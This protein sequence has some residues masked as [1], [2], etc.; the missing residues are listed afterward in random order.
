MIGGVYCTGQTRRAARL[1]SVMC[2]ITL[3]ATTGGTTTLVFRREK[4][5]V[6]MCSRAGH[7]E[8]ENILLD[9]FRPSPWITTPH[10]PLQKQTATGESLKY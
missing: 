7:E 10:C 8:K 6:F 4:R 2:I 5:G 1:L 3:K 9:S